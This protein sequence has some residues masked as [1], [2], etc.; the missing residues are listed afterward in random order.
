MVGQA[1]C[2]RQDRKVARQTQGSLVQVSPGLPPLYRPPP[3]LPYSPKNTPLM[4]L[5]MFVRPLNKRTHVL[6]IV[7]PDT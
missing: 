7:R 4:H 5:C 1:P 3:L 2:R 6:Y